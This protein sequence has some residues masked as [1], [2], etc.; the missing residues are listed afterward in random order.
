VVS[1]LRKCRDAVGLGAAEARR[2]GPLAGAVFEYEF[3]EIH[4]I[5][6]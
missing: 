2:Q 6:R 4:R 5:T 1:L 3:S